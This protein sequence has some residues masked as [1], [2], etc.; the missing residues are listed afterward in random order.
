MITKTDR[1][2]AW[3]AWV[4][5]AIAALGCGQAV[6]QPNSPAT[7]LAFTGQPSN[8]AENKLLAPAIAVAVLDGAGNVVPDFVEPVTISL[9]AN[10][11]G[12]A[13]SGTKTVTPSHGIATFSDLNIDRFGTGYAL[14]ASAAGLGAATSAPFDIISVNSSWITLAP[15][16][17]R[18]AFSGMGVLDGRLY[19]VG[20][21]GSQGRTASVEAYDPVTNTWTTRASLPTPRAE[22]AVGVVDGILY[23]VG[24]SVLGDD[25]TANVE[26]YD[27]VTDRW[28]TKQSMPTARAALSVA[29]ANGRLYAIGGTA[30]SGADTDVVEAYDPGSDSWTKN[31]A[32]HAARS[33]FGAAV[34]DGVIYVF[35]GEGPVMP[36]GSMEAYDLRSDRWTP[37]APLLTPR[38]GLG[39]ASV[40]GFIYAVGGTSNGVRSTMERY[41]PTTNTWAT[42]SPMPTA[43]VLLSVGALDGILFAI[44]GSSAEKPFLSTNEAFQELPGPFAATTAQP[45]RGPRQSIVPPAPPPARARPASVV[46]AHAAR[47]T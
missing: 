16:P 31:A 5:V 24:G 7:K 17:T 10:P 28:A 15:L 13:L 33:A 32:L 35:G 9:S 47:P 8:A 36:L 11:A 19:V 43:R 29:V 21:L 12:G 26:A 22:L 2:I 37:K 30:R 23:A 18:R 38:S 20:G 46:P 40:D 34:V 39:A 1:R 41:D 6:L 44:G 27:P 25:A 3:R 42:S 45:G 4:V 14:V